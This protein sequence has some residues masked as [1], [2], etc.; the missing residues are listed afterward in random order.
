MSTEETV[1][2]TAFDSRTFIQQA[3]FVPRNVIAFVKQMPRWFTDEQKEIF[4]SIIELHC[5]KIEGLVTG[6]PSVTTEAFSGNATRS[7]TVTIRECYGAV[8]GAA[9]E[10][11]YL[12]RPDTAKGIGPFTIIFIEPDPTQLNVVDAWELKNYYFTGPFAE[13]RADR[14][15]LAKGFSPVFYQIEFGPST[16]SSVGYGPDTRKEAQSVLD[17]MNQCLV[18][19]LQP[20]VY[21]P[22]HFQS[23]VLPVSGEVEYNSA[24]GES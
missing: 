9:I 7:L 4:K 5:P 3:S 21:L 13:R 19:A 16:S 11:A 23:A 20:S 1:L 15:I 6:Y 10:A 18:R 17:E 12:K 22:F 8:V 14:D 24:Q 2:N